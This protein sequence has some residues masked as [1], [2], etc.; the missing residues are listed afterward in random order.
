M[1]VFD[2]DFLQYQLAALRH[3]QYKSRVLFPNLLL[4]LAAVYFYEQP[5]IALGFIVLG[6]AV[7]VF[8]HLR[9]RKHANDPDEQFEVY[10]EKKFAQYDKQMRR[11]PN[12]AQVIQRHTMAVELQK[13]TAEEAIEKI[14]EWMKKDPASK[15]YAYHYLLRLHLLKDGN[16]K[17]QIPVEYV[18]HMEKAVKNEA[19][20]NLLVIAIQN[21]FTLKEYKTAQNLIRKAEEE[22]GRI[23]KIRKPAFN[24]VYK[25]NRIA[26]SY[27]AGITYKANGN[28]QKA[29]E[30][31]AL[32]KKDCKSEKLRL[33]IIEAE[34]ADQ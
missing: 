20:V 24:A 27:Y 26:L 10:L 31:F 25:T 28:R 5:L 4:F 32:A 2:R 21:A 33:K 1:R 22:M 23:R 14:K 6:F 29:K 17:K 3:N 11:K 18:A 16:D 7:I 8:G 34:Q 9:F 12:A 30:H 13:M 19:N 15:R